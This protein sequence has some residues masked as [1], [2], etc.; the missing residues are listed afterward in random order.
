MKVYR[1]VCDICAG[2]FRLPAAT[3]VMTGA[4]PYELLR[5]PTVKL[6]S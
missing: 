3:I 6:F 2:S 5:S 1:E 4:T